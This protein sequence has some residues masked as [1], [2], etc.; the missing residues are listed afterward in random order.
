[1]RAEILRARELRR[2]QNSVKRLILAPALLCAL[3]LAQPVLADCGVNC[4]YSCDSKCYGISGPYCRS[5]CMGKCN[6]ECAE[7]QSREVYGAVYVA[8]D[9]SEAYGFSYGK[10]NQADAI[11]RA[12]A[13]CQAR[14]GG[15][16]RLL[17][18]VNRC[19]A[20]VQGWRA[21]RVL[22]ASGAAEPSQSAATSKALALCVEENPG[23]DCKVA[24]EFCP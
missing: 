5:D 17:L 9:G 14:G 13:E 15:C 18:F 24:R 19:A 3:G 7:G 4:L 23:A 6:R 10:S 8:T 16:R 11:D 1:M 21:G 12:Q 22:G 2:G 20:I